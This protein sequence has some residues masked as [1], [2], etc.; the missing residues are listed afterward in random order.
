MATLFERK[1]RDH[2][3]WR[4]FTLVNSELNTA[5]MNDHIVL[6]DH[7]LRDAKNLFNYFSDGIAEATTQYTTYWG[8]D[9][10]RT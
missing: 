10:S 3:L 8:A 7:A 5:T 6:G 1:F 4:Q 2:L 9:Q